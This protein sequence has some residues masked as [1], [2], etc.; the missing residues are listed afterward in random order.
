MHHDRVNRR[1]PKTWNGT[2]LEPV[3]CWS[4]C[5]M[6]SCIILSLALTVTLPVILAPSLHRS[7]IRDSVA[8]G[9]TYMMR[10]SRISWFYP[11]PLVLN[12]PLSFVWPRTQYT[13][14][15]C[16]PPRMVLRRT[17][18]ATVS[19]VCPD[20][21]AIVCLIPSSRS[22]YQHLSFRTLCHYNEH[23]SPDTDIVVLTTHHCPRPP[24]SSTPPPSPKVVKVVQSA[25]GS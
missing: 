15:R 23:L 5:A 10:S 22:A 12:S 18:S 16:R 25:E 4:L 7:Y 9:N 19:S 17:N 6:V 13:V 21:N 20:L 24:D 14:P 1:P 2:T 11:T 8:F 3:H